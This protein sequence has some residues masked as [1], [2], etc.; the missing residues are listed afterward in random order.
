MT[1]T[2]RI[3]IIDDD[4]DSREIMRV[5]LTHAGHTVETAADGTQGLAKFATDENW[6]LVLLDQMMPG[7]SGLDMLRHLRA[8][9]PD[10][11]VIIVTDYATIDIAVGALRGGAEDFL[12]KPFSVNVLHGA[13]Q[14]ALAHPPRRATGAKITSAGASGTARS[15]TEEI[16][17]TVQTG[18]G[19]D[20]FLV[21]GYHFQRIEF[22]TM[23]D[24]KMT[25]QVCRAF[26]VQSPSGETRYCAVD[27]ALL[28]REMLR[29]ALGQ[30]CAPADPV[31]DRICE[32]ALANY[33]W[34]KA[35][36]CTETL[37][38]YDLTVEQLQMARALVQTQ[39][40]ED[41]V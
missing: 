30:D 13:V 29:V 9:D 11:K 27:V 17:G 23:R 1:R 20:S 25:M 2:A 15:G 36:I 33:L 28:A 37:R 14:A 12:R 34:E 10:A 4:A 26:A 19:R 35:S 41:A 8:H 40:A 39:C 38:V 7:M 18:P 32:N 16:T 3:L 21:N 24:E 6:D 5:V 31:W 22:P